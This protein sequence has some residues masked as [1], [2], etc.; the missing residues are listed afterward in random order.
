[1]CVETKRR[2]DHLPRPR[3]GQDSPSA[4]GG[5]VIP[6]VI[7]AAALL[8][9]FGHARHAQALT[10]STAAVT[11]PAVTLD[12]TSQT[13][14][15]STS[16]WRVDATGETGGWNLTVAS[17][18]FT[19]ASRIIGVANFTIRL[20]NADIAVVAGDPT[21]PSSTQITHTAL[22]SSPLKLA[23]AAVADGNGTYDLTPSFEL[24]VPA[25]TYTGNYAATL[26]VDVVAGP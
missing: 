10:V 20:L 25:E 24:T 26:T 8:A 3:S 13:I 15:G 14:A 21:G 23:S 11:F 17:T 22:S 2:L 7:F 9:M 5:R 6:L 1:M 4:R 18:D 16:A 12:G 19:A